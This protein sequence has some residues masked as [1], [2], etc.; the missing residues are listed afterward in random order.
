[1]NKNSVIGIWGINEIMKL[2]YFKYCCIDILSAL[3]KDTV[4]GET[5]PQ[6]DMVS[7]EWARTLLPI[8]Q[9]QL[10]M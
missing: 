1:M 9:N 6:T 2:K 5:A 7:S 4:E 10:L 3:E 8:A